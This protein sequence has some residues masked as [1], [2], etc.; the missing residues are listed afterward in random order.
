MRNAKRAQKFQAPLELRGERG[1]RHTG[2]HQRERKGLT[3]IERFH[4]R[5]AGLKTE[6]DFSFS[7]Q[8]DR[9]AT[10]VSLLFSPL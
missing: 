3:H 6:N 2:N 5:W 1:E 10:T 7:F 4:K 8:K 9:R